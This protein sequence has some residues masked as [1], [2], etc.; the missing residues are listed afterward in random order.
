[1]SGN[2]FERALW[3]VEALSKPERSELHLAAI[4][5]DIFACAGMILSAI[6]KMFSTAH[7]DDVPNLAL[8]F[9]AV[10]S[11]IPEGFDMKKVVSGLTNGSLSSVVMKVGEGEYPA[12]VCV[13]ELL[14]RN[15][16]MK[17]WEFT[18]NT[19]D[20]GEITA[21]LKQPVKFVMFRVEG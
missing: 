8:M 21:Q 1:M 4:R 14:K 7:E 17:D 3:I 16:A 2:L 6:D 9:A 20:N 12:N 18:R 15:G 13:I 19:L 10:F 5:H 11:G